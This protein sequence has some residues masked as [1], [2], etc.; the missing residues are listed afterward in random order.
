MGT[1][2]DAAAN[3]QITNE[4]DLK[5]TITNIHRDARQVTV[6]LLTQTAPN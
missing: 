5:L 2:A 1:H 4:T 3:D 6:Y